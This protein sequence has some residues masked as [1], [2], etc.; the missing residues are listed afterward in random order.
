MSSIDDAVTAAIRDGIDKITDYLWDKHRI[1]ITLS[2]QEKLLT[3]LIE[4]F[5]MDIK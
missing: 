1:Q 4:H 3:F 2:M 5:E